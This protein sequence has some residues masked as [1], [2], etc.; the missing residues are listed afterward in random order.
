MPKSNNAGAASVALYPISTVAKLT[1][2]N[3]ITLRA[4]ESRYGLIKPVRKASGHRLYT[5]SDI[6]LIHRVVGLLDRGM[7]IGEVPAELAKETV[8]TTAAGSETL[9]VW[10]RHINR[11]LAAVIRFDEAALD[12]SYTEMQALY[13]VQVVTDRLLSPL[14]C[15]LGRRWASSTGS[16]AEEHFFGF[17]L[18]S[19]LGARFHH[20]VRH[21]SGP[22]ILLCCLPGDRHEIGLLLFALAA[23][24]RGLQVIILG[25][26]MPL[27]ELPQVVD[28]AD[29]KAIILSGTV[30]PA[31]AVLER[32]LP[33]LVQ[34]TPV[35]VFVGGAASVACVGAI[36]RAGA[37][38]CGLDMNTGLRILQATI[39]PRVD[40]R[41]GPND[42]PT[43]THPPETGDE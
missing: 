3:A 15:E 4:W 41:A 14:L 29:C 32:E 7:R 13:Q 2:V 11:M 24:D 17:Y 34:S 20:R 37:I 40:V 27:G 26:D 43:W 35:P 1:N 8:P 42:G 16:V 31:P 36:E 18:R 5:Q 10:Q 33:R 39:E 22:R 30:K 9:D 19:K 12:A 25:S 23:N 21:A 28:K 6:D 38:A